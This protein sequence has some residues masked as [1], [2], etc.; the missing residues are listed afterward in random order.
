MKKILNR[1]KKIT[2]LLAV[3]IFAAG[4]FQFV[5]I[6][7]K[8]VSATNTPQTLPFS[9]DW[10][11][12]GLITTNDDWSGVPG[13]VGFL[14][15][16]DA[17]APTNVDPRTLLTP[18]VTNDVDAI[19]NQTNPDT[20]ASGGVAEFEI[21]NPTVALNGSGTA[22]APSLVI[23]LNTTGQS[24]IQFTCNIRDIDNSIDNS[25]QQ[26]DVQY[27]VGG[28]GNYTSV[29]GGYIADA[30]AGPS[31][32]MTTPL[33]LTLPAAANNQAM[34]EIRIMTTNAGGNDEWIGVDDINVTAGAV[35]T[36]TD[37]PLD[38][39]GDGKTD[40][41]V[42]RNVGGGPPGQLRWFW[43]INGSAA[44]T[45]ASDWGLSSDALTSADYDGDQKD[46]IAVWRQGAALTAAFYILQSQTNTVRVEP[47]GQTGDNPTVVNDYNGDG[48][49]DVAVYRA[50]TPTST[51]FYRTVPGGAITYVAWGSASD[52]VAPGDW[53]GDGTADFG[54][55]RGSGGTG[56]F[57]VRLSNG[58]TLPVVT[59]GFPTDLVVT[60]DFDGD[61]KT[62]VAVARESGG[63]ITWYW[64]P[65]GGGADQQVTFGLSGDAYAPG[66]YDGDG[67]TDAGVFRNGVF[68][69]RSTGS[70]AVTFF[71]LGLNGDLVPASYNTH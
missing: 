21:T 25:V 71:S 55:Q 20:L 54:V 44:P 10:T 30:S 4:I 13:I 8:K 19:A 70:G 31:M 38:F 2:I 49:D 15:N 50:G 45:A 11:N 56:Q 58:A 32:T 66:D 52:F 29:P 64:R 5:G 61:A 6:G 36:P 26:I 23:Y 63:V 22:D 60:G 51:W 42:V 3:V 35:V 14:G 7:T 65:S 37:A 59:F 33:N 57:W 41:V 69:T 16:Y 34:V 67:R 48:K 18:F 39:N 43:N 47:F 28:T 9:Q 53:N 12:V 40:W 46:D 68:Y 1:W 27:R 24:N 17:A 62:D